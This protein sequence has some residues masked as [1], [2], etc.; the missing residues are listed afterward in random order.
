MHPA[1]MVRQNGPIR[2]I[3]RCALTAVG[4]VVLVLIVLVLVVFTLIV[5]KRSVDLLFIALLLSIK[6]NITIGLSL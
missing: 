1:R 2:C 5:Y 4:A 6:I 3:L